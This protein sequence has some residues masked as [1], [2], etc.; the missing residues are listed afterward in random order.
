MSNIATSAKVVKNKLGLLELAKSLGNISQACKIMGYS[1]ESFYIYT[2]LYEK[3]GAV[4]SC[5]RAHRKEG[6]GF[7]DRKTC[8]GSAQSVQ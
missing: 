1:I 4:E 3:G 2:E 6:L 7:C 5:G 8:I